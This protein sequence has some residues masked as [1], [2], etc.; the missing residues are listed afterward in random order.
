M[1]EKKQVSEQEIDKMAQDTGSVLAQQ[2]KVKVK[3]FLS[4]EEKKSLEHKI[5]QGQSVNWPAEEVIVNGY[6]YVIQKGKEVEVPQTVKEILE[7]AG[8]I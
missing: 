6:K 2:D 5:E 8:L 1:A 4:A 7:G 3:L